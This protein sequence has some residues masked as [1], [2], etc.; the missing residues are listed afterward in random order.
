[1]NVVEGIA[2]RL[3]RR[4]STLGRRLM[5]RFD[6]SRQEQSQREQREEETAT[7]RPRVTPIAREDQPNRV[8]PPKP[9]TVQ[10]KVNGTGPA[11]WAD[12]TAWDDDDT[13][14]VVHERPELYEPQERE[15]RVPRGSR[16][17]S[18]MRRGA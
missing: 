1:M 15:A 5:R 10:T 2:S 16:H 18:S 7:T 12:T 17:L 9:E 13:A 14:E 3:D 8:P 4:G 6:S 11:A